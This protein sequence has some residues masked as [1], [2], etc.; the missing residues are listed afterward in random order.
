MSQFDSLIFD[1]TQADVEHRDELHGKIA[2]GTATASEIAEWNADNLKG[3]YNYTDMNRVGQLLLLVKSLSEEIGM[4]VIF[5]YSIVT[6]YSRS[7]L[8]TGSDVAHMLTNVQVVK[9]TYQHWI[10]TEVPSTVKTISGANAIEWI[11]AQV[12]PII[13]GTKA[14]YQYSAETYCGGN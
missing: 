8:P 7:S 5:P 3:A 2:N 12:E 1:R 13:V 6:N 11:L 4:A 9:S 14:G 10:E